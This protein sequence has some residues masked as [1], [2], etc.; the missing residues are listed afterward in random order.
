MFC[1]ECATRIPDESLFCWRCGKSIPLVAGQPDPCESLELEQEASPTAAKL[2]LEPETALDGTDAS[3][4]SP[5]EIDNSKLSATKPPSR[6][7]ALGLVTIA[8]SVLLSLAVAIGILLAPSD[9]LPRLLAHTEDPP[10]EMQISDRVTLE[11]P[12]DQAITTIASAVL[13]DDITTVKRF[14]DQGSDLSVLNRWR[15]EKGATVMSLMPSVEMVRLVVEHGVDPELR[16]DRGYTPLMAATLNG[17]PDVVRY[18]LQKKVDVTAVATSDLHQTTALD[19]AAMQGQAEIARLLIQAGANP[20]A[21][22]PMSSA[23]AYAIIEKHFETVKVLLAAGASVD[24]QTAQM[25]SGSGDKRIQQVVTEA[26]L[27]GPNAL[28][29]SIW[30]A[31]QRATTGK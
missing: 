21:G 7:G 30:R 18:L 29:C 10:T 31:R 9:R 5:V 24:W 27:N 20:N 12:V 19:M 23:L 6:V 2:S 3:K 1:P 4:L 17:K 11:S 15:D 28:G 14:V 22:F 13:N 25:A 16:D 26:C 8:A